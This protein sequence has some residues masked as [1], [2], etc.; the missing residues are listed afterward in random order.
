METWSTTI[1]PQP[2][3]RPPLVAP[4]NNAF[5]NTNTPL[6]VWTAV[7]NAEEYEIQIDDN[8]NFS[9]PVRS[10]IVPGAV[11]Q[12]TPP[13]LP[14][15]LLYWRVRGINSLDVPGAWSAR[16]A[17][18]VD[19]T[20]PASPAM[21]GPADGT[22]VTNRLLRLDWTRVPDAVAYQVQLDTTCVP[23]P[24]LPP[25]EVGNV[26]TYKPPTTLAQNIYCWRVRAFDRRATSPAGARRGCSRW[27]R[28]T[29][30]SRPPSRRRSFRSS[31]RRRPDRLADR[32]RRVDLPARWRVEW[33]RV[34]RRQRSARSGE[35]PGVRRPDRSDGGA[36][37]QLILWQK[38]YLEAGDVFTVE[39]SSMAASPGRRSN[40]RPPWPRTGCSGRWTCRPSVVTWFTCASSYTQASPLSDPAAVGVWLDEQDHG[41]ARGAGG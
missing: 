16:R 25:I 30:T 13:A 39:A 38:A 1:T 7:L 37:P 2:P 20:P 27:W 14:E 5:I 35:R 24:V 28:V 36:Q 9:S 17:L 12:Y 15:G 22:R 41:R 32:R 26:I 10:A 33:R 3:Q 4:A 31:R 34:V 11:P 40:S 23:E 8:A 6:F 19:I 29:P 21:T 18:T